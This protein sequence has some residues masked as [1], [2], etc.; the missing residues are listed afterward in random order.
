MWACEAARIS[1]KFS[2]ATGQPG[3]AKALGRVLTDRE[4]LYLGRSIL[5]RSRFNRDFGP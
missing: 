1:L 2:S 5:G 4:R 3:S